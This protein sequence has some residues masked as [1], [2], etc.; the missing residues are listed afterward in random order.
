MKIAGI[1][2]KSLTHYPG[3]VSFV[4][5]THGCNFS[6][7]YCFNREFATIY[8]AEFDNETKLAEIFAQLENGRDQ[9][10]AVVITGGEP[11]IQPDLLEF[12]ARLRQLDFQIKL[13]T[14]GSNPKMIAGAINL[15][16]VD[17]IA[18]DIKAP[19]DIDKYK[20]IAGNQIT[21]P[22]IANINK[23]I[24]ILTHSKMDYEVRTTVIKEKH[25][26][27]DLMDI[28]N[29]LVGCKRFC[30]QHFDSEVVF[31]EK[32]SSFGNYT[33]EELTRMIRGI[34]PE[35]EEVIFR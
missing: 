14:N 30:L 7:K 23:T 4:L 5:I 32:F 9:I 27:H 26:F 25:S 20:D 2:P 35:I 31:D 3:L 6:C 18:V 16:L 28:C 10:D 11:T 21:I 33:Q 22:I 24:R 34:N 17:F 13:E 19:F 1:I 15:G 12:L 8:P 29:S